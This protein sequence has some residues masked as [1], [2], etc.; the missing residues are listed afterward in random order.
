M[1]QRGVRHE[2]TVPPQPAINLDRRQPRRQRAR[3]HDMPRVDLR[4]GRVEIMEIAALDIDRADRQPHRAIIEQIPVDQRVQRRLERGR[5]VE[6]H[7]LGRARHRE[8]WRDEARGEEPRHAR[9]QHEARRPFV[10][11]FAHLIVHEDREARQCRSHLVPERAQPLDSALGRVAR[12]DCRVDRTDRNPRDPVDLDP[13]RR[14]PLD[15]AR[16]IRSERA[17][18]LQHQRDTVG[19][20]QGGLYALRQPLRFDR[21]YI[22]HRV[23][24]PVLQCGINVRFALWLRHRKSRCNSTPPHA[25]MPQ[26]KRP[27]DY[28]PCASTISIRTLM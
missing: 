11:E 17:A 5:I 25:F 15:H 2:T 27:W 21:V 22:G 24:M 19:E 28:R 10:Q 7:R 20:G 13:A 12:H 4:V 26:R 14:Q 3:C 16:L 6:A 9:R 18:A 1:R 23:F 8:H